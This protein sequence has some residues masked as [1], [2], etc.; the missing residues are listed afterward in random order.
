MNG[1][2]VSKRSKTTKLG[3]KKI[4]KRFLRGYRLLLAF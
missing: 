4:F 3:V 1:F 2:L